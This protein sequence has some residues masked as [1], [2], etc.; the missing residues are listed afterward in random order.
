M[1]RAADTSAAV[2]ARRAKPPLL[3]VPGLMCTAQLWCEQVSDLADV[4]ET[5]IVDTTRDDDLAAMARRALEQAPDRFSLAGLSMGG[6]VCF[7]ML[8]QQP[9]RIGRLALLDTTAR[10]DLPV[11]RMLRQCLIALAQAG[12]Y[13]FAIEMLLPT[14]V[15]PTGPAGARL[16]EQVRQMAREVGGDGAPT[17]CRQQTAIMSRVD[18]RPLLPRINCPTL[19]LCGREDRLAPLEHHL[20]MAG[21]IPGAALVILE[22]CAHLA[23]LEQPRAVNAALRRWL[24]GLQPL[25]DGR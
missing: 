2:G 1:N 14:F 7:E 15:D 9:H 16:A 22:R 18:S 21:L 13:A 20:E 4:A 23:T 6:Y 24:L 12:Q 3:L 17:F 11:Q 25:I 8:R 10:P 5:R 19:V